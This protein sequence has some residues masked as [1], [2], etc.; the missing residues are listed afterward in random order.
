MP[1]LL[2][3]LSR[4]YALAVVTNTHDLHLVP[5][6]LVEHGMARY[7][8]PTVLSVEVGSRKPHPGIFREAIDRVGVGASRSVF[9]GDSYV[10]DYVGPT[11]VGLA[12]LL[13]DPASSADIPEDRRLASVLDVADRLEAGFGRWGG[14]DG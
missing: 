12:A 9:V 11:R 1:E 3:H 10:P 7:V 5:R 14:A 8:G 6:L 13:I 2:R 4:T